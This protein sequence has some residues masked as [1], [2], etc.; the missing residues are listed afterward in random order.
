[1]KNLS[2]AK[3]FMVSY[4]AKSLFTNLPLNECVTLAVQY[5]LEGNLDLKHTKDK[6]TCLFSFSAAQTHFMHV[7]K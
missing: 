2:T 6:L 3:K 1:M 7:Q 4:D 5:I